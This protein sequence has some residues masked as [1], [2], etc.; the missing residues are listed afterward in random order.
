MVLYRYDYKIANHFYFQENC[1]AKSFRIISNVMTVGPDDT[2]VILS[3]TS[4]LFEV[5]TV[6]HT[7][8]W[9]DD[10]FVIIN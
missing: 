6:L 7:F 1:M 8:T 5:V 9:Y 4:G 2:K 3:N 10:D